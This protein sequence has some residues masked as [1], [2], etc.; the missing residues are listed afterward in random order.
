MAFDVADNLKRVKKI[1]D[2]HTGDS[3]ERSLIE[4]LNSVTLNGCNNTIET[5]YSINSYHRITN[6]IRCGQK[7]TS[8]FVSSY[9]T[10]PFL[11]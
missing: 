3:A 2:H 6:G 10:E 11:I 5:W 8:S 7:D 9:F 4:V 1:L